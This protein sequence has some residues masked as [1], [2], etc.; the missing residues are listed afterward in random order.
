MSLKR[1]AA[2]RDQSE[3]DILKALSAVGAD[4]LLLDAV[5][6]LVWYRGNLHL[7]ECKTGKGRQTKSQQDLVRRGW[8]LRFVNSPEQALEA[9]GLAAK[10]Q[11]K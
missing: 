11:A 8:P 1:Y 7:L 2:K 9:I 5:D 3:R 10:K 6:V 4:Y